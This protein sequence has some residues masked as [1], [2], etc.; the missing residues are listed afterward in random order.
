[1]AVARERDIEIAQSRNRGPL[2]GIPWGAK[3]LF[4]T[5]GLRTTWGA[6]PFRERVAERDATVVRRLH[7]AGAILVAKLSLG[8]LAYNDIWFGGR[9]RNPFNPEQGSS[10]S[11]AGSAAATVAGLVGFSLGTET[12]GSIVSPCMRCGATGLR[13]TFGRVGRG[14]A[15]ALC[16]SL[17]K[18]GPICRTVE[19]C[20][21][22]LQAING[23]DENDPASIE[24]PLDFDATRPLS[25]LQLGYDPRWF[26][27]EP[28]SELDR[29]SLE[30]ARDAGL[31]LVEIELPD[32]PYDQLLNVL[33]AEAAAAFED[34]TRSGRDEE[35]V[36]QD[37]E[38]WPNSF[39]QSWFIPAIEVIQADRFR[40]QVMTMMAG[41]FQAV[42]AI[43]S[44]SYAGSLLL[45]TNFTG[46][47]CLTLRSGFAQPDRPRG[48]TLWGNLFREGILARIGMALEEGLAVWE[49]RP[50]LEEPSD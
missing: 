37:P 32:W 28:A 17:D 42:D 34:L 19:D 12:Y 39:R 16:W 15:M 8:A 18:I 26:D 1:M 4:D 41:T 21:L 47:P 20:M 29:R 24:A 9:T 2:H 35:L 10:G 40:R 13:P 22:V 3:D 50:G 38:A 23:G 14:G 43:I 25:G 49:V 27:A 31:K 46:H 48:I 6:G 5:A 30:V 45:I 36:W 11:S 33:F 7:E 44:P